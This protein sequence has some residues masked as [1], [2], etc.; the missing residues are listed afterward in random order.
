MKVRFIDCGYCSN[1]ERLVRKKGKL[2]KIRFPAL[3]VYIEHPRGNVLF[4]TGYSK[5]FYESVKKFPYNLY[6][7]LTPCT[8][9][10]EEYATNVLKGKK[11]DLILLSHFHADHIAGLKDF[12]NIPIICSKKEYFH[13]KN[14]KNFKAL[15]EGF[16]PNLLPSDYEDRVKY[17]EDLE[18]SKNPIKNSVFTKVYD[19]FD[20]GK[21]LVVELPGHSKNTLGL[22]INDEKKYFLI[23]DS[24]WVKE[25]Y[26]E[27]DYPSK[28][29]R[30]IMDDYKEFIKT[31]QKIVKFSKETNNEFQIVATHEMR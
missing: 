5:H 13:L 11:I 12:P 31:L 30:L 8:V 4:D 18:V 20:D 17:I 2:K 1:I 14:K 25:N 24:A 23:S 28:L 7:L 22:I 16:I 9:K 6:G 3:T 21:L 10:E 15:K 29:T 27:G 19:L 26:L